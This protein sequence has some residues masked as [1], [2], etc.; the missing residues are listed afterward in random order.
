MRGGRR[1]NA[2]RKVDQFGRRLSISVRLTES[3]LAYLKTRGES[4]GKVMDDCVRNSG[5]F[6]RWLVQQ[7][8][9]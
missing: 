9:R 1:A 2:G 5:E 6:R 3:V 7:G 8:G 4:A